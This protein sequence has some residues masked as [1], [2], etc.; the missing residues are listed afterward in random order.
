MAEP[1][2]DFSYASHWVRP[3]AEETDLRRYAST[4]RE[5]KKLILAAVIVA[6][7]G[8]I[9]YVEL[10]TP[11][12]TAQA[13]LLVAPLTGTPASTLAGMGLVSSSADPAQDVETAASLASSFAVAELDQAAPQLA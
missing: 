7:V 9:L 1:L 6:L 11:V 2:S 12:Y 10:A 5:R 8:A 4:I 13:Q 3:D